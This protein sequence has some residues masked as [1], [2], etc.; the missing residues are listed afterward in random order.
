M[1]RVGRTETEMSPKYVPPFMGSG[2]V[3]VVCM[4]S[5]QCGCVYMCVQM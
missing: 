1:V 4:F 5:S 3:S 2:V